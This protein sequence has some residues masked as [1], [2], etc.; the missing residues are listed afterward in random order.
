MCI[1]DRV[2]ILLPVPV[3][4]IVT[5]I[6]GHVASCTTLSGVWTAIVLQANVAG[7]PV[8]VRRCFVQVQVP[9]AH[10]MR[11]KLLIGDVVVVLVLQTWRVKVQESWITES[12][13]STM[14][15]Q[16][17]GIPTGIHY[18]SSPTRVL[19]LRQTTDRRSPADM[20]TY[21]DTMYQE[22]PSHLQ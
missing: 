13:F 16:L 4:K 21:G 15:D 7:L 9:V 6:V 18:T 8:V 1:R 12:S 17:L 3:D 14:K 10:L 5:I 11:T 2:I 20:P 22:R 19:W